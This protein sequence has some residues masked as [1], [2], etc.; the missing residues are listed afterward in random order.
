MKLK[1]LLNPTLKILMVAAVLVGLLGALAGCNGTPAVTTTQVTTSTTT[2]V[3]TSTAITT[4]ALVTT[5]TSTATTTAAN[6]D[7]ILSSTTSVRDSG[8]MDVLIPMF[9]KETGYKV[10]PIY[11]G[12]GAAIA[13]G[14]QG[15]ADVLVVHSPADEVTFV[16]NG[17]GINRTLFATNDFVI[18]GPS[19]DPAGIKGMTSVVA[20]FQKIAASKSLFYSRGDASGTDKA[21]KAIWKTA[22]ITQKGQSWY[23]EANVGMGDLLRIASEKQGYTY[24]DRATYIA[25]KSTLSLD[26]LVQNDYPTMLNIYHVIEVNPIKFPT[27]K[28]NY[29]GAKAFVQFMVSNEAQQAIANYGVDKYGQ[30]LFFAA[31]GKTEASFGSK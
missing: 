17:Y 25:Q 1:K 16:A 12:S 9:E 26:I 6:K 27:I 14:Q 24:T 15:Q 30:A 23:V 21:E 20:A 18:V 2:Q 29:T 5:S 13:L 7:L 4:V 8:L 10:K 3:V 31:A 22:G 28:L 11:N 19:N